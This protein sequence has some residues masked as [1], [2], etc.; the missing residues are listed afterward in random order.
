MW[1]FLLCFHLQYVRWH[2]VRVTSA[3]VTAAHSTVGVSAEVNQHAYLYSPT[4]IPAPLFFVGFLPICRGRSCGQKHCPVGVRQWWIEGCNAGPGERL[5]EPFGTFL[6]FLTFQWTAADL[7]DVCKCLEDDLAV[8]CMTFGFMI[9]LFDSSL[10]N[11]V[12]F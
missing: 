6:K 11:L 1:W 4:K 5:V 12:P 9:C 10:S 3:I 2:G 8:N 7:V